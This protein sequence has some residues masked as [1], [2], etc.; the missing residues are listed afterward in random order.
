MME[1]VNMLLVDLV[2]RVHKDYTVY[3]EKL[4][5]NSDNSTDYLK[6]L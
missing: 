2:S 1:W 3:P 4:E 5:R 6:R